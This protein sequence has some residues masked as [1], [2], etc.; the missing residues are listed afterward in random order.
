MKLENDKQYMVT[1]YFEEMT[2]WQRTVFAFNVIFKNWTGL[3]TDAVEVLK[4][5]KKHNGKKVKN[6]DI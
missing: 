2:L 4:S 6:V 1:I 3:R 5:I